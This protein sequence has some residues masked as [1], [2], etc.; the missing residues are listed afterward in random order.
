MPQQQ[1][2]REHISALGD[3]L[4]LDSYIADTGEYDPA[5]GGLGDAMGRGERQMTSVVGQG[6][7][8]ALQASL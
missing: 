7:I 6:Q 4:S 3:W 8:P 1:D 5:N 2:T